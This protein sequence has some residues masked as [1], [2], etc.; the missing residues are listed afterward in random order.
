MKISN[1]LES[2][3]NYIFFDQSKEAITE[4]PKEKV[5]ILGKLLYKIKNSQI[6]RVFY[7]SIKVYLLFTDP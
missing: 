1:I 2:N 7:G 4:I 3:N 6:L 5:I